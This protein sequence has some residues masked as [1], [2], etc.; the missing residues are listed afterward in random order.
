MTQP[1]FDVN[2]RLSMLIHAGS[3]LGKSTLSG[4]APKPILVLDAEGSWRFIPVRQVQWDPQASGPP[5][6]DGSWDACVVSIQNWET[7][8]QVYQWITQ[9][10]TPF[11][12]VVIDSITELQRRLKRKLAGTDAMKIADWGV[13]LSKMDDKI[14][15][16]RDLTLMPQLNIRCVL[17]IAETR[18]RNSD[19]KWV[20][21]M[22]GQITT[23][24][25][26]WVDVCGY[27]YA[28]WERDANGQPTREVRRLWISP[29]PE[30]EAGERVQGRLGQYLTI[31][32]P[33][34]GTSGDD[35]T[36]WMCTVFGLTPPAASVGSP[37]GLSPH[38]PNVAT[39]ATTA[40]DPEGI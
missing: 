19:N 23:A 8:D 4:T 6:Y 39:V 20:P 18:Q 36:R 32:K 31:E 37:N 3:K 35:V 33:P 40:T 24:L 30:Y 15:G 7:I 12:T 22:Q 16:F 9:Y 13:L 38:E 17:F 11:V 34:V 21:Y 1:T 2:Q 29:H 27:M 10:Q 5:E 25:P 26:Y 28:D 14:R